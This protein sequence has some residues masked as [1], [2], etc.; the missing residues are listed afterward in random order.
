M[1]YVYIGVAIGKVLK[2]N[3]FTVFFTVRVEF[4]NLFY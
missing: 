3:L 2:I 4:S 1:I